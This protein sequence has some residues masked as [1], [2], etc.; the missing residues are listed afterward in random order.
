VG[1]E[2]GFVEV[3][4]KRRRALLVRLLTSA[5]SAVPTN[6][7]VEDVWEL[8]PPPGAA[9]TLQTHIWLL[10]KILG[11]SRLGCQDGG[12]ILLARDDE[13]DAT[14]FLHATKLGKQALAAGHPDAARTHLQAGL[15]CWRGPA[16]TDV[17]LAA[18]AQVEI[19]HYEEVRV[20]ALETL[21]DAHL[22]AGDDG[23][24]I[25]A[26][27]R[28]MQVEPFRERFWGQ[29][30][31]ALY[32]SGRQAEALRTYQQLRTVLQEQLGIDPSP[33]LASLELAILT[34]EVDQEWFTSRSATTRGAPATP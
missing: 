21:I 17:C 26:S 23:E 2:R 15:E 28:A 16:L 20:N 33:D 25:V 12:Y 19:A 3:R 6:Q 4:G 10:R 1:G 29:H 18:W 34:Q 32:R 9:S 24:A 30:M 5:N 14:R 8:D 11:P 22:Q 31:L 13:I 7:L 27:G